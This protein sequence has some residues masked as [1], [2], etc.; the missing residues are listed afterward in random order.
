MRRACLK[1]GRGD[2]Y[3]LLLS[4][5]VVI[6][7]GATI[8][9][10]HHLSR[11][12]NQRQYS[13]LD[14]DY[15]ETWPL[16]EWRHR[17]RIGFE[18]SNRYQLD[19]EQGAREWA[20]LVPGGDGMVYLGEHKRPFGI[21]VFHQLRCLDILRSETVTPRENPPSELARHCLNYIKQ[22]MLCRGD[23]HL[24]SFN[25]ASNIDPIDQTGDWEC[26]DWDVVYQEAKRNQAVRTS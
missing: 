13:Y 22:M 3:D 15:P 18:N 21:S 10:Q 14:D 24:E 20:E 4:L 16:A 25:Y 17:V 9:L 2:P 5:S 8:W 19:T 7:L 6:K 23:V 26:R 12:L 11:A 1:R